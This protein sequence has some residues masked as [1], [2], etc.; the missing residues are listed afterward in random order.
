[1]SPFKILITTA[2]C[3]VTASVFADTKIEGIQACMNIKWN[4]QFLKDHPN[5][6][7]GCQEVDTR[8]GV[9]YAKFSGTVKSVS[10][11]EATVAMKNVAGTER[12]TVKVDVS[13]DKMITINGKQQKA[14]DV[15]PGD[16]LNFYV[17]EG[18]F[19]ASPTMEPE[20]AATVAPKPMPA[21]SSR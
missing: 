3:A 8:D 18:D 20:K 15:K 19:G 16:N 11:G 2:L 17:K 12:G 13:G 21:P 6:P 7:A 4:A 5:A 1:M 14:A 10:G 9:R